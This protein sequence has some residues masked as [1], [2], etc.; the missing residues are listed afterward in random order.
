MAEADEEEPTVLKS[1]DPEPIL[2]R[3]PVDVRS[4]TL[5]SIAVLAAIAALR[6]AEPV[7]IPIVLGILI[8]Y[9]LAP[10]VRSMAKRGVPRALGAFIVIAALCAGMGYA[11]YSLT[12]DAMGIV[13]DL[14]VAARNISDRLEAN[15]NPA[16]RNGIPARRA[17]LPNDRAVVPQRCPSRRRVLRLIQVF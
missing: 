10:M 13:E 8:S 15:R 4:V 2:I 17:F 16:E 3:M 9:V 12:D 5:T 14:P 6:W 7:I 11:V 1:D